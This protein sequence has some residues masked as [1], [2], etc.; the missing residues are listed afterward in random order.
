MKTGRLRLPV[1]KEIFI[2]KIKRK[3]IQIDEAL[4]NGCGQCVLDCAEG[5]IR[6]VDGK[7]KVLGES[8]CDGLGACLGGCPTGA[9]TI[10][11]READP[12][13]EAAV[14]AARKG[15]KREAGA[16]LPGGGVACPGL[17]AM[18]EAGGKHWPVKLRLANPGA[19]EFAGADLLVA[20]D[21]AA[22]ACKDFHEK[23]AK[24]KVVLIHCP[25]FEDGEG[26]AVRLAEIF[27][28]ARPKSCALLRMEVPCCGGLVANGRNAL[29]MC[30]EKLPVEEKILDVGGREK[31]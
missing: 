21:C 13:D 2:M 20:A 14:H 28:T 12:F 15:E 5:A 9:L 27:K 22:A 18:F 31:P 29:A 11:E 10:V 26:A 23:Y 25:K 16:G 7:A 8:L 24:G 4:C 3:I 19:P 17:R 1:F 6:I 30:G